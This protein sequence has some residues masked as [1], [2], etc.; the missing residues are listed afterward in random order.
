MTTVQR[1]RQLLKR[2]A[3]DVAESLRTEGAHA[4]I[5]LSE[6]IKLRTENT[7]GWSARV[8]RLVAHDASLEI[9]ADR[10]TGGSTRR[11]YAGFAGTRDVIEQIVEICLNRL[12]P[13]LVITMDDVEEGRYLRLRAGLP[14][15]S[16]AAPFTRSSRAFVSRSG[17]KT[18]ARG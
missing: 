12:K 1:D 14:R 9:W 3:A 15:D 8:G 11:L 17:F 2:T 5:D 4:G 7:D 16:S 18:S 13:E 10:W 6:G